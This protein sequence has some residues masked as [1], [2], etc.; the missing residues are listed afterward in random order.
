MAGKQQPLS[1]LEF[2]DA[3]YDLQAESRCELGSLARNNINTAISRVLDDLESGKSGTDKLPGDVIALYSMVYPSERKNYSKD[4][5][6]HLFAR[7]I[8]YAIRQSQQGR[9]L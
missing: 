5:E 8:A 1:R 3:L 4:D 6:S 9:Q 2:L 7:C